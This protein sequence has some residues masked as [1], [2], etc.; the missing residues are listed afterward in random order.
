MLSKI[1][2][3]LSSGKRRGL[4]QFVMDLKP[5]FSQFKT[6]IDVGGYQGSFV[7]QVLLMNPSLSIHVFEPFSASCQ[8]IKE[9]FSER[10]AVI[11]NQM[12]V[13]E[14]RGEA[15]LNINSFNETNSLLAS[16]QVSESIDALTKMQSTE[17]VQV[18]QLDEYCMDH[19]ITYIDL[20]KIDT[21]GNSFAVLKGLQNMLTQ[22]R[23]NYLYVEAEFVEIYKNEKLFSEI[24]IL[25]REF[26]Y[27]IVDLYNL[28]YI[29]KEKLGWC[30]VLFSPKN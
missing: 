20:I 25:M 14:A 24:E 28:N 27:S 19:G 6:V 4:D 11:I 12:A 8:V 9:K 22:K 30:D 3:I 7:E 10:P 1:R 21:Q 23:I 15:I 16:S 5:K 18:V 17:K 26:G 13:S 29:N 2:K